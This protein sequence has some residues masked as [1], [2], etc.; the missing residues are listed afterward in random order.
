[1]KVKKMMKQNHHL[2][3]EE[4]WQNEQLKENMPMMKDVSTKFSS[5]F[6]KLTGNTPTPTVASLNL[7]FLNINLVFF[8][9]PSLFNF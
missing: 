5:N 4:D 7:R 8:L 3:E 6:L 2:H 9:I 1:M